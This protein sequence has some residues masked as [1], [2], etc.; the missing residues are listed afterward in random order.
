MGLAVVCQCASPFTAGR[1]L[2]TSGIS[3]GCISRSLDL[4]LLLSSIQRWLPLPMGNVCDL[5]ARIEVLC[6]MMQTIAGT[7]ERSL[8]VVLSA[9]F[10]LTSL[11]YCCSLSWVCL[12]EKSESAL[13]SVK[14]QSSVVWTRTSASTVVTGQH[15]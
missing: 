7:P 12:E 2:A 11:L 15:C 3:L 6:C 4:Q 1:M 5:R 9:D 14:K 10:D 8:H 13:T